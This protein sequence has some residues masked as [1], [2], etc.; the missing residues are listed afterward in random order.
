[1]AQ[2][3]AYFN[4]FDSDRHN[5]SYLKLKFIYFRIYN[6]NAYLLYSEVRVYK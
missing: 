3:Y 2:I 5:L 4:L 6:M 1:M